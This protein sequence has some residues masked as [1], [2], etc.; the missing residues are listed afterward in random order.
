M[1][2]TNKST[3]EQANTLLEF[4]VGAANRAW[5]A[6]MT[7]TLSDE[8]FKWGSATLEKALNANSLEEPFGAFAGGTGAAKDQAGL[9]GESAQEA[10]RLL[11]DTGRLVQLGKGRGKCL[12]VLRP[13]PLEAADAPKA[14]TTR[15]AKA[16]TTTATTPPT[17]HRPVDEDIVANFQRQVQVLQEMFAAVVTERNELAATVADMHE[18][19][20]G[21]LQRDGDVR[22]WA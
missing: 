16:K 19:L 4:L 14:K 9:D 5:Q 8:E 15:K 13:E 22:V 7:E 17:Q 18:R 20:A 11:K 6:V 1:A 12:I 21:H 10:I 2:T 3:I